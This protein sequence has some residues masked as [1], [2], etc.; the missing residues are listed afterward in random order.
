VPL[1][2]FFLRVIAAVPMS[3]LSAGSAHA[4]DVLTLKSSTFA[5]GKMMLMTDPEGRG[6]AGVI[7]WVVY[8]IPTSVTGFAEGEVSADPPDIYFL[9]RI[10]SALSL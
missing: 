10:R 1:K 4:A 5:D 6:G 3:G 7:H 9:P 8:G 2:R